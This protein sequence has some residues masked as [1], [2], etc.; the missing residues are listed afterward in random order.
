[1]DSLITVTQSGLDGVVGYATNIFSDVSI[2]VF[3][4]IGIPLGFY[5]ARK[6]IELIRER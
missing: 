4:A 5:I 1:M 6:V 3:F 2:L